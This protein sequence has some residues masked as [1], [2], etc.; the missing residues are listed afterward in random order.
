MG[1]AEILEGDIGGFLA[2]DDP[3]DYAEKVLRLI[4]DPQLRAAKAAEGLAHAQAWT[5]EKACQRM[6]SLYQ[7]MPRTPD[8]R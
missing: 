3:K 1:T 8:H 4:Q 7:S 6:E 5:T 2:D